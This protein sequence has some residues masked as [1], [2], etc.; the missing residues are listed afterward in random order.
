MSNPPNSI[1]RLLLTPVVL[2]GLC[3]PTFAQD[4]TDNFAAFPEDGGF[5]EGGGMVSADSGV[6]FPEELP[7][8]PPVLPS[9]YSQYTQCAECPTPVLL[10]VGYVL[11]KGD[12]DWRWTF[13]PKGFLYST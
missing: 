1:V 7:L 9:F 13:R 6:I 11:S 3:I 5:P 12:P 10:P 2:I 8:D 4:F